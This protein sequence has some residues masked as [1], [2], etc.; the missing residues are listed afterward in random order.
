MKKK[1]ISPKEASIRTAV[2]L[3]SP[4]SNK[5]TA[6]SIINNIKSPK[7][8]KLDSP[9][10]NVETAITYDSLRSPVVRSMCDCRTGSF[11]DEEHQLP[12]STSLFDESLTFETNPTITIP[13]EYHKYETLNLVKMS[14]EGKQIIHVLCFH[15]KILDLNTGLSSQSITDSTQRPKQ[16]FLTAFRPV[17]HGIVYASKHGF[18]LSVLAEEYAFADLE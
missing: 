1:R 7:S 3:S 18:L 15:S 13:I 9:S 12:D 2:L 5:V 17:L 8:Q 16:T 10:S 6:K 4:S 11:Y 14:P